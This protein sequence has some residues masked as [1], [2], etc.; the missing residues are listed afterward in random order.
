MRRMMTAA[1]TLAIWIAAA[2]NGW[3]AEE[4]TVKASAVWMGQ[5]RIIPTGQGTL[6][7]FA[8]TFSGILFVD[9]A[10]GALHMM[11]VVCPGTLEVDVNG[12]KQQGQ[13]RCL[14]SS[15]DGGNVYAQWTCAGTHQVDCKGPFVLTGG[16]GRFAGITGRGDFLVRTAIAHVGIGPPSEGVQESSAGIAEWPALQYRIP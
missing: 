1:A 3:G 8:G 15:A 2:A 5:G 10:K 11:K 13:G 7:Y 6:F 12:G 14:L 9:D 16:S 4:G